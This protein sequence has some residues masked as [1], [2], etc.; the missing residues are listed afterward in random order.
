LLN[1]F[2]ELNKFFIGRGYDVRLFFKYPSKTDIPFRSRILE[3]RLKL[4]KLECGFMLECVFVGFL[5]VKAIIW[6]VKS[7]LLRL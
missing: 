2:P 7:T 6:Q 3:S 4:F 5:F 1:R